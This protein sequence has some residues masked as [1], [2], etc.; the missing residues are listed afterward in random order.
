[1]LFMYTFRRSS[2][3]RHSLALRYSFSYGHR[4]EAYVGRS[5]FIPVYPGGLFRTFQ[6]RF[7]RLTPKDADYFQ[8]GEHLIFQ[9]DRREVAGSQTRRPEA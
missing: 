2:R 1:M 8:R 4:Q 5:S 6:R 9:H 3:I 7:Q